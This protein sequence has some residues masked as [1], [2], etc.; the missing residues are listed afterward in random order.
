M[1]TDFRLVEWGSLDCND[2]TEDTDQWSGLVNI[3][4]NLRAP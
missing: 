3:V 2:L 1:K 4:I